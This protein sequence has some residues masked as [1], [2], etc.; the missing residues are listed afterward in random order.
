MGFWGFG[1][2]GLLEWVDWII[3]CRFREQWMLLLPPDFALIFG[4]I[5]SF[6]GGREEIHC[7]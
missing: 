7:R 4:T 1:V 3:V 5:E 6:I 2:L